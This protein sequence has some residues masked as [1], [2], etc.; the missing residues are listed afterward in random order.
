MDVPAC[1]SFLVTR[2]YFIYSNLIYLTTLMEIR[3]YLP[4]L[5]SDFACFFYLL[6]IVKAICFMQTNITKEVHLKILSRSLVSLHHFH[7]H[8]A[9]LGQLWINVRTSIVIWREGC[10]TEGYSGSLV[11]SHS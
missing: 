7:K 2:R 11:F 1:D 6:I 3:I 9:S 4:S 5:D 8:T 10:T